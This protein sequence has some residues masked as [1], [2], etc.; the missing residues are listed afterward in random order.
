MLNIRHNV[1]DINKLCVIRK[2]ENEKHIANFGN[3]ALTWN[4]MFK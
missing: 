2:K 3:N 4:R 1:S